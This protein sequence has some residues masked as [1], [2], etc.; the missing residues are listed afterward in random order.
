MIAHSPSMPQYPRGV[1]YGLQGPQRIIIGRSLAEHSSRLISS[2]RSGSRSGLMLREIRSWPY[3]PHHAGVGT[4]SFPV[5]HR[6][7]A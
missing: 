3:Q 5:A 2:R 1:W 4:S 7:A 6:S